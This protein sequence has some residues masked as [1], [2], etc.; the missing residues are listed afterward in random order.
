MLIRYSR[1]DLL[2]LLDKHDNHLQLQNHEFYTFLLSSLLLIVL[3]INETTWS[4]AIFK[5]VENSSYNIFSQ[6]S[7]NCWS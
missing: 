7:K 1:I 3:I 5:T 6:A 4:G 2:V